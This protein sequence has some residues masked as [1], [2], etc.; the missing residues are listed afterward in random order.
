MKESRKEFILRAHES[1]CSDWKSKIETEFPKLFKG[2][3]LVVGNWYRYADSENILLCLQ[4]ENNNSVNGFGFDSESNWCK[5]RSWITTGLIPTTDKEV[6]IALFAEAKKR[7]Y[8]EGVKIEFFSTEEQ[9]IIGS[10]SIRYFKRK[11][12]IEG[13]CVFDNG[14]WA[15]IIPPIKEMTLEQVQKELGYEIKIMQ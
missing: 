3:K 10:D 5:S 15:T 8:K 4:K 14:K 11:V 13:C 12:Y 2:T 7:G 1:A 9:Q 6:A